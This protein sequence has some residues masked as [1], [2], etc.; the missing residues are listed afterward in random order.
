MRVEFLQI[1]AYSMTDA[2]HINIAEL[3]PN[4]TTFLFQGCLNISAQGSAFIAAACT[5]LRNLLIDS[6][7]LVTDASFPMLA[8]S[9][10]QL[11]R[12]PI[13]IA[14]ISD[15]RQCVG[16]SSSLHE[17]EI[18]LLPRYSTYARKHESSGKKYQYDIE[19]HINSMDY[20]KRSPV[21]L[22]ILI[23]QNHQFH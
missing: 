14:D 3:L 11:E 13:Q 4:V 21:K 6:C 18:T 23:Q 22:H 20:A 15:A 10:A 5:N 1:N 9:W 8:E 16:D 17:I 7:P 12:L 2:T 19:Q